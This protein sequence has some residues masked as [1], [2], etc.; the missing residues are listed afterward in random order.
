MW[1]ILSM[2]KS[3]RRSSEQSQYIVTPR[4]ALEIHADLLCSHSSQSSDWSLYSCCW[5]TRQS[6]WSPSYLFLCVTQPVPSFTSKSLTSTWPRLNYWENSG[7]KETDKECT[8]FIS[9]PNDQV[10]HVCMHMTQDAPSTEETFLHL[11]ISQ[12]PDIRNSLRSVRA[13]T[14]RL[15]QQNTKKERKRLRQN[16][17]LAQ[18]PHGFSPLSA[19]PLHL[20][21]RLHSKLN[22]WENTVT[23]LILILCA[24]KRFTW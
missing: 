14:I 17:S 5:E 23:F 10:T 24:Q 2:F 9:M 1:S 11:R 4:V 12:V 7:S 22:P 3:C 19:L 21:Q 6:W 20:W 8:G 15:Q 18:L 16:N 13:I